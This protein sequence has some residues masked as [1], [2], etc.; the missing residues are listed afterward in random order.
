[1]HA[2]I[3]GAQW[4]CKLLTEWEPHDFVGLAHRVCAEAT[5]AESLTLQQLP[6]EWKLGSHCIMD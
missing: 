6:L 2:Y 1:M 5:G 4:V 3:T